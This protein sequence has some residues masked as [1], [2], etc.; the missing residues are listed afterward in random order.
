[1]EDIISDEVARTNL[2]GEYI[3]ASFW[4][5]I[6]EDFGLQCDNLSDFETHVFRTCSGKFVFRKCA[7]RTLKF[8]G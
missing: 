6:E 4:N 8:A 3:K 1:M 2:T 7:F 5:K